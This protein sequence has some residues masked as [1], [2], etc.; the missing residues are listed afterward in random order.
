MFRVQG[1]SVGFMLQGGGFRVDF[2]IYSSV[3]MW[4]AEKLGT[5][6]GGLSLCMGH[7]GAQPKFYT[8]ASIF[9]YRC[10]L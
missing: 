8:V 2:R 5:Q 6:R 4:K 3:C 7:H 1:D 9:Q 10:I